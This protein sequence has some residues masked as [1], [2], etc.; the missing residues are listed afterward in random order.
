[1][2]QV[3][4]F[5]PPL[6]PLVILLHQLADDRLSGFEHVTLRHLDIALVGNEVRD[7]VP[8]EREVLRVVVHW[9]RED[10][11]VGYGDDP[12]GE[13]VSTHP[14]TELPELGV[15]RRDVEDITLDAPQCHTVTDSVYATVGYQHPAEDVEEWLLEDECE[16]RGHQT[17][18]D[19]QRARLADEAKRQHAKNK[20][21]YGVCDQLPHRPRLG[22]ASGLR[23]RHLLEE[24]SYVVQDE[25]YHGDDGRRDQHLLDAAVRVADLYERE[26]VVFHFNQ[27][28]REDEYE[29]E[30]Y[31]DAAERSSLTVSIVCQRRL[32]GTDDP[33]SFARPPCWTAPHHPRLARSE[34]VLPKATPLSSS[35]SAS[36]PFMDSTRSDRP[37]D[38][39]PAP[40]FLCAISD[41][42]LRSAFP[43]SLP[44]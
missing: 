25:P 5:D 7:L 30:R 38:I 32:H 12:P 43:N 36:G 42:I 18:V 33:L 4:D 29:E 9:L 13:G 14:L 39:I 10:H 3:T 21:P 17:D 1:M 44:I 6:V 41:S 26:D 2:V 20:Y 16:R 8:D 15:H 19:C 11:A 40:G 23:H 22:M 34:R 37:G 24:Y 35:P 27:E 31:S 28:H